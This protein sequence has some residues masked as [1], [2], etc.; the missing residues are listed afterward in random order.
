MPDKFDYFLI[1]SIASGKP[2]FI[3]RSSYM[4][5]ILSELCIENK[6]AFFFDS[7]EEFEQKLTKYLN[8]L[9]F[10]YKKQKEAA[11]FIRDEINNEKQ[12][13]ILDNFLQKLVDN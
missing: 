13:L 9:D 6:T 1:Q 10:R 11:F 5:K 12:A 2:L 7:Y 8:N 3:K 4:P